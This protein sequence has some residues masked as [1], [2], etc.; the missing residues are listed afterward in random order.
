[1]NLDGCYPGSKP[2]KCIESWALPAIFTF[3]RCWAGALRVCLLAA[4]ILVI[5]SRQAVAS[6][7][8]A[9]QLVAL[10]R[11]VV[12][13]EMRTE[14]GLGTDNRGNFFAT[15]MVVDADR[16]L[17]V[18]NQHV[19]GVSPPSLIYVTFFNG[20][21]IKALQI[22]YD[23]WHD[24]AILKFNPKEPQFE[25]QAVELGSHD[26]LR[27]N[28]PLLLIG[29]NERESYT[30]KRGRL[31]KLFVNKKP[32]AI[33]RYSHHIH[34][35]FD[36]TGGSSG[37]PVWNADAKVVGLHSSGTPTSSYELRIDYITHALNQV[38]QGKVPKRGDAHVVLQALP[39]SDARA[40]YNYP[41]DLIKQ[42]TEKNADLRYV[43]QVRKVLHDSKADKKLKVGDIV[44]F[45]EG[46]ILGENLYHFD[47][48]VNQRVGKK[49]S[50]RV[51]R[52]GKLINVTLPVY[53]AELS[54]IKEFV[55]FAG[56]TFHEI[57][58]SLAFQLNI[59]AGGVF[60][61]ESNPG[62]S[63]AALGRSPRNR[64]I[65]YK[66]KVV[67]YKHRQTTIASL[68]SMVKALTDMAKRG[69]SYL[70]VRDMYPFGD[71]RRSAIVDIDSR[72]SPLQHFI[73]NDRAQS[74][75]RK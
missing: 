56:G 68:E 2:A 23:P 67:V 11:T 43:L 47:A 30:I 16:G 52:D 63:F 1:M 41:E 59:P 71:S 33:G 6:D 13:V 39:I 34:T 26:M 62:S 48:V 58:A 35:D 36:R 32:N 50:L 29:N 61:A 46:K 65:N 51:F 5:P 25:I 28:E 64:A 72:L 44:A 18:T 42:A 31:T 37:S 19:L 14:V 69:R 57:P 9:D 21:K 15:G 8:W 40:Y 17:I 24:F 49:V 7:P 27:E 70:T 10:K 12:N 66:K 74:W 60:M 75:Q 3:L 73:W 4:L 20:V 53:D 45:L 55:V 54:K 22:Y 38:Q